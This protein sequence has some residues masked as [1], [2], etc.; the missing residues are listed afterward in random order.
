MVARGDAVGDA[1]FVGLTV[2]GSN[3]V[4]NVPLV[5]VAREWVPSM[6]DPAWHWILLAWASTLAGNL[7]IFGS[8]ANVIVLETAGPRGE[9]GFFRFL[10]YGSVLTLASC[11][12]GFGALAL[13][14]ALGLF[15][16]VGL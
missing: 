11:V 2:L 16:L 3:V 10:R 5:L 15:A 6:P 9:I 7:T 12:V 8:V 14:R 13:E 4:S 1:A